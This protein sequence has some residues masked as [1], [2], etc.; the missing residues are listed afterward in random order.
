M[1]YCS[2]KMPDYSVHII[3]VGG[4]KTSV[5]TRTT[6]WTWHWA[7]NSGCSLNLFAFTT[8]S[9]SAHDKQTYL[10]VLCP[11]WLP[12]V[13]IHCIYQPSLARDTH[14]SLKPLRE[15]EGV[16]RALIRS[17]LYSESTYSEHADIA[18]CITSKN[19]N[20][21]C[22]TLTHSLRTPPLSTIH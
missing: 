4:I 20:R 3:M 18:T 1:V 17:Y 8:F 9:T 13:S 14:Y 21:C 15:S 22:C 2:A 6:C 11:A 10:R 7:E 16:S 12:P 5:K 19:P